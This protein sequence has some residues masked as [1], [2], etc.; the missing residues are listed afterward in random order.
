[1]WTDLLSAI[2]LVFIIEGI[3]PFVNPDALRRMYLM[4]SQLSN[5]TLRTIG[6]GSMIAGLIMLYIVRQ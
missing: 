5:N 1:M 4:A 2:A 3:V 6:L